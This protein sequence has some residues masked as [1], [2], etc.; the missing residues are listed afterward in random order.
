MIGL[1]IMKIIS[2]LTCCIMRIRVNVDVI[3]GKLWDW[4]NIIDLKVMKIISWCVMRI[5]VN[6]DVIGGK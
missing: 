4:E 1:K 3:G 2:W 5:G 6:V